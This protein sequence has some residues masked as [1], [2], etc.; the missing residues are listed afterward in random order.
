MRTAAV[1][2]R[3]ERGAAESAGERDEEA[4]GEQLP[5]E[6]RAAGPNGQTNSDFFPPLG[7]TG[8]EEVRE[9]YAGEE[10]DEPADRGQDAGKAEDGVADFR[11]EK[12]WLREGRGRARHSRDNLSRAAWSD[13]WSSA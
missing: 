6:A 8:E 9:I 2:E 10:E 13:V 11:Q 4:F 5:N 7:R 3:G 12:A 1:D